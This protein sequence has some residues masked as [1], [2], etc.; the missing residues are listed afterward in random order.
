[1]PCGFLMALAAHQQGRETEAM[2]R[3]ERNRAACGPSGLLPRSSTLGSA[4]WGNIPQA[5]VHALL[6]WNAPS[7]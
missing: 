3:W 7:S 2:S 1:M 6:F 4:N 5:C